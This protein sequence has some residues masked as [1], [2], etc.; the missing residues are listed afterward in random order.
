MVPVAIVAALI[1]SAT[2]LIVLLIRDVILKRQQAYRE[3]IRRR[4]E[5]VYTPLNHLIYTVITS[6]QS[7]AVENA[8]AEIL[9]ILEEHGHL[10]TKQTLVVLYVLTDE[11]MPVEAIG[12][13]VKQFIQEYE[14]LRATFYKT[15]Y[16]SPTL[17][18]AE[19]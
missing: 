12:D 14:T 17:S 1:G 9:T 7:K 16:S 5:D 13:G 10:L 11:D 4:L 8:R 3:L 18:L 2:T 19:V 6:D 15:H